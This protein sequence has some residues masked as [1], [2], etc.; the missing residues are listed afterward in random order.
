[1]VTTPPPAQSGDRAIEI[2]GR[3]DTSATGDDC[4]ISLALNMGIILVNDL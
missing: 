2:P 4:G 1:M 3:P